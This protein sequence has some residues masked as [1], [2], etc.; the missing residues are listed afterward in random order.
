M[1]IHPT[2]VVDPRAEIHP[3]AE[4][5]PYVVVEGPVRIGPR[6]RV[7]AHVVITGHT[8]IGADNVI[9]YGAIVGHEPQDL[10]YRGAPTR[11]CIGDRNVIREHAEIHRATQEG[12]TTL[13]GSDVYLM[14]HAHVAHNCQIGD[15]AIVCSGALL[16]GHVVVGEQA[17]V[18]GNCVV[19]QH[20]RIGR[21][22]ILRGLAR[23]SR[24]VPPFAILDGTH[25]VRGINRV[26]LRRAG[27]DAARI[28][29][30]ATAFRLLF[31][32]RTNLGDAMAHVESTVQSPEV[33]ELL[34]FIRASRRG[35]AMGPPRETVAASVSVEDD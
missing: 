33:S 31:R 21:L 13:L 9:H 23:T 34:A 14:S 22:A 12:T 28:R 11:L 30:L 16:A 27:F 26:G 35:V 29:A 8:D 20:V 5:G 17:F 18:S 19:H 10:A 25:T 32:V 15:R 7:L 1:P 2:A 3:E 24:D 6:T 4:I